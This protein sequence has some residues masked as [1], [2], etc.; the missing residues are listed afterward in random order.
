VFGEPVPNCTVH[1]DTEA[2]AEPDG[3]SVQALGQELTI[4]A[5]IAQ[6]GTDITIRKP[7]GEGYE[8]GDMF[9][10]GSSTYEVTEIKEIDP[11]YVLMAV[12]EV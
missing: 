6:I 5:L 12:R 3:Y 7:S 1:L 4:E 10:I 8:P 2:E 9:T 11:I